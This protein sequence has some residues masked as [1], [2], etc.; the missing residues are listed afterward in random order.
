M[1]SSLQPRY[2]TPTPTFTLPY[3]LASPSLELIANAPPRWRAPTPMPLLPSSLAPSSPMSPTIFSRPMLPEPLT[4]SQEPTTPRPSTV[5]LQTPDFA[6]FTPTPYLGQAPAATGVAAIS[7]YDPTFLLGYSTVA[8]PMSTPP[9]SCP[10]FSQDPPDA[11][12]VMSVIP[13]VPE[14]TPVP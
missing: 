11:L 4:M 6:P 3:Y 5:S 9:Y 14:P 13:P 7:L 12:I 10:P 1:P 8:R 2:W